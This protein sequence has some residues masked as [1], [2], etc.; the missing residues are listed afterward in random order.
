M[1]AQMK[2]SDSWSFYQAKGIKADMLAASNNVLISL[3]KTPDTA[4]VNKVKREKK[5]QAAIMDK[6]KE[7]QKESDGHVAKHK[8]MARGV[9]MFQIAIAIGAISIITKRRLLWVV[10]MGF[11]AVGIVFLLQGLGLFQNY[12]LMKIKIVF[13]GLCLM[14]TA[15]ASL[16]AQSIQPK[17]KIRL[18]TLDPGH[19]HAALVQK[20]MYPDIDSTVYVYAP[21]GPDVQ[22]HLDRIMAYNSR[23][24]NPTAWKEKVYL[25]NDFLEKMLAEKKGNVVVLAG[26]NRRKTEYIQRSIEGGFNVLGD[27]P[28]AIDK[29]NFGLLK[30]TFATAKRKKLVLYD[31]M[32]ERYEIT[33][34]L[35]RELAM[36]PGVFGELKKGTP[37]HP[38]VEMESVHY[39][40][41]YVSGSVLTRPDWAF[42][43]T[44]QGPGLQD[45]GVHLVDLTQWECFPDRIIDYKKD[46]QFNSA[47]RWTTDITLSQFNTVTQ[48]NGFPDFLKR[49]V[50]HDTIL[51][52]YANGMVNYKLFGVNVK[53]TAKW[54]YKAVAG[55][56]SQY[57]VL[58][59][60]KADL[61]ILQG[62]E[63]HYI[64]A[65]Y[66][67]PIKEKGPRV[68]MRMDSLLKMIDD[69]Y[70]GV[71]LKVEGDRLE[72]IIPE[73]YK[74]G[75]EAHFARVTEKFLDYVKHGDMP[76]WEVPDMIAKY[77]TTTTALQLALK[78]K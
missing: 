20:S 31:I 43:I 36:I 23:K 15:C 19:F 11:A 7:Y 1:L 17:E 44:Q 34:A 70:P 42:D 69:K 13:I 63:Q 67:K 3:G 22:L 10:S 4:S 18:I 38:G 51:K 6:A 77:Y 50:S 14:L 73:S 53:L 68:E 25:G 45:V 26:N 32:T 74:D 5:E 16:F 78:N 40:Y 76:K 30:A 54:A 59:G 56:D 55:G 21:K 29:K 2:S 27:K 28:M 47:K 71:T 57:S 72:V 39:F 75:H 48:S 24:D 46:I 41:K 9:T 65:L 37:E 35:Q 12:Q 52:V 8:I 61:V 60:T 58:H 66:I 64:P 33:N 62:A 49:Y